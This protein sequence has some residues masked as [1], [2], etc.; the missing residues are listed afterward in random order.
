M[1][2]TPRA[3]QITVRIG[4]VALE[5]AVQTPL[6]LGHTQTV[7]VQGKVIH[8]DVVIAS[9]TELIDGHRQHADL[10]TGL[11]QSCRVNAALEF[12]NCGV[13]VRRTAQSDPA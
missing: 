6:A 5:V 12:G 8:P 1:A 4:A 9:A 3:I 2:E 10:V 13:R 11:G 7:V